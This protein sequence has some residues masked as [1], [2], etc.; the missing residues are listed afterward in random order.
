MHYAHFIIP[1]LDLSGEVGGEGQGAVFSL[2]KTNVKFVKTRRREKRY[3]Y[4]RIIGR[5]GGGNVP[6]EHGKGQL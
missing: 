1:D 2:K 3:H 4:R 6:T 5:F